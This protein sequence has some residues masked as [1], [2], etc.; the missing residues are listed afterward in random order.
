[1]NRL[2]LIFRKFTIPKLEAIKAISAYPEPV[3]STTTISGALTQVGQQLGGTMSSLSRT[4]IDNKPLI[5]PVGRSTDEGILWKINEEVA[6]R[7]EIRKLTEDIL[8][9]NKGFRIATRDKYN[10]RG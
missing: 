6:S 8:E 2:D 9:E 7:E 4:N 10:L 5:V 3:V 1:M